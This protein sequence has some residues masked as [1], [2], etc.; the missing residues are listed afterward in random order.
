MKDLY[1]NGN[2][3]FADVLKKHKHLEGLDLI[4]ATGLSEIPK[5]AFRFKK[6]YW[7]NLLLDNFSRE[8]VLSIIDAEYS[9]SVYFFC[10]LNMSSSFSTTVDT[11]E[12]CRAWLKTVNLNA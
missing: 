12:V 8:T 6:L 7:L 3:N 9:F 2:P 10:R 1:L 11:K 5:E 4:N